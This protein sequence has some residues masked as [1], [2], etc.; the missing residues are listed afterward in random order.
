MASPGHA[1]GTAPGPMIVIG[2]APE[3][4]TAEAAAPDPAPPD[5]DP[6]EAGDA[7]H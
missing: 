4:A 7:V 5:D 2:T 6:E 3:P 1:A